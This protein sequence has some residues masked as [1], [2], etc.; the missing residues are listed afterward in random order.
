MNKEVQRIGTKA[1][2]E[3]YQGSSPRLLIVVVSMFLEGAATF[4]TTNGV[5]AGTT[6]GAGPGVVADVGQYLSTLNTGSPNHLDQI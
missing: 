2:N 5:A 4:V 1:N 6:E 3:G